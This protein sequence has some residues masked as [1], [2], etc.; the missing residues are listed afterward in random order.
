MERIGISDV[1]GNADIPVDGGDEGEDAGEAP[2]QAP[3]GVVD[4]SGY[5]LIYDLRIGAMSMRCI[6]PREPI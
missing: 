3:V 5:S 4:Q 1:N 6:S 2:E